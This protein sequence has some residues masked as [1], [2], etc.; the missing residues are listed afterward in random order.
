MGFQK[1]FFK[2]WDRTANSETRRKRTYKHIFISL[3]NLLL[4][5]LGSLFPVSLA[6][7]LLKSFP[8]IAICTAYLNILTLISLSVLGTLLTMTFLIVKP[9]PPLILIH[10]GFEFSN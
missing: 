6:D 1:Y 4:N 5:F 10:Y 8:I 9:F 3:S 7:E 2:L